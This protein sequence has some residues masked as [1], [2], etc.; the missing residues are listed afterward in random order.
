L[1]EQSRGDEH[2]VSALDLVRHAATAAFAEPDREALCV[3]YVEALDRAFALR[4]RELSFGHEEVG[5]VRAAGGLATAAAVAVAERGEWGFDFE[6][7][8]AAQAGAG[9]RVF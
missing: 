7:D 2:V 6:L 3:R 5:R 9:Y 8:G 4:P 1:V